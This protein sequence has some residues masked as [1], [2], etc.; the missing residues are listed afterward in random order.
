[1]SSGVAVAGLGPVKQP[2]VQD[3]DVSSVLRG[4][5]ELQAKMPDILRI[6]DIDAWE[7]ASSRP[8]VTETAALLYG[9]GDGVVVSARV[10][11]MC[12]GFSMHTVAL[13]YPNDVEKVIPFFVIELVYDI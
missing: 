1:L 3:V 13:P 4:H 9:G 10:D 5:M 11:A 7:H 2:G 8:Y 12:T 6:I